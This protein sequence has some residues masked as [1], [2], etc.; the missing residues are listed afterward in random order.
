MSEV[1]QH[2]SYDEQINILFGKGCVI[3]N[4]NDCKDILKEND[5]DLYHLAFPENW[6]E[7][8]KK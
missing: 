5:I 6:K 2:R 4:T 3:A 7:Q 1:K 8:L